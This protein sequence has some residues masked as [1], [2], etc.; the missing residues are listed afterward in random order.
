MIRVQ[1]PGFRDLSL[2]YL[3]LDYNGTLATNGELLPGVRDRLAQLAPDL[4]IHV[5]TADTF[6][7]ARSALQGARCKLTVLGPGPQDDAKLNYVVQ[8]G[9][10]ATVAI[11]N[12]R[13]DRKMLQASA[14]GIAVIGE[15]GCAAESL[16]AST[17]VA[18]DILSALDLL[19][20]PKR[21]I[22]TLRS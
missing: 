11:G 18:R 19:L 9:V 6:G 5:V 4:A 8:L 7:Q 1:V 20:N 17:I 21:L 22:A 10:I 13:N 2:A 14:L 15:E 12:G 16:A 3:V